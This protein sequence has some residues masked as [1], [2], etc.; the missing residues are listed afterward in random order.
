[1]GGEYGRD[2]GPDTGYTPIED[3]GIIG[4]CRTGALVSKEGSL[5]WLCLPR[6]DSPSVFAR[7]LDRRKG[8][9]F[10]VTP[11]EE[12]GVRRRY[13]GPTAVLETTFTTE[14]GELVLTDLMPVSSE[15]RKKIRPWPDHHVLRRLECTRGHVEVEAG[16]QPRP[17]YGRKKTRV[18]GHGA[19][20]FW[21]QTGAQ[22]M[23]LVTDLPLEVSEDGY[24]AQGTATLQEGDV[25]WLSFTWQW[26]APAI[27]L[28]LGA[29]ADALVQ[30]ALDWWGNWSAQLDYYGPYRDAVLR[31]ALT[32]KLLTYAPS[33]AVVAALTTSLP[34]VPGG[35][36]NWD[37]RY[38]WLRDSSWMLRALYELGYKEEAHAF[39]EWIDYATRITAPELRTMYDIH[40]GSNLSEHELEH[41]EGYRCSRPVNVGNGAQ[42]QLQLDVYGEV[43]AAAYEYVKHGGSLDNADRGLLT[44][45]GEVV[46]RRW[47]EGDDGIWEVRGPRRNHTYSKVMCW[48]ALDRLV[49]LKEEGVLEEDV[50]LETYRKTLD[51]IRNQIEER[52]VD[53]ELD[54]YV[55]TYDETLVDTS[56]LRIPTTGYVKATDDRFRRTYD[57]ILSSLDAGRGLLYRYSKEFDDLPGREGAFDL[58]AF[59]A[60]ECKALAGRVDEAREHFEQL[61]HQAN[62]LGLYSEEMDPETGAFLGNFPQ[63]FTHIGLIN[64]AVTIEA[65]RPGGE[66]DEWSPW[67]HA[68]APEGEEARRGRR[69]LEGS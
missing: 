14:T 67:E 31:S 19:L 26:G 68:S 9:R 7:I 22:S 36:R 23:A 39:Y 61:L 16:W 21:C 12:H 37:Y 47:R 4:N 63:A 38:C 60:V 35:Q 32:L 45:I 18:T 1:M 8:G 41:L 57:H 40:G 15:E 33:G 28:P 55:G 6:F 10:W 29:Y 58:C 11:T 52:G 49:R 51:E 27:L 5:D 64:A 69:A 44:G 48:T 59:W 2:V 50:P 24:G 20:G 65:C 42:N 43:M 30:E 56:L 53:P 34:E 62:D 3:Y 46:H 13:V 25:R 17:G 66:S 54:C